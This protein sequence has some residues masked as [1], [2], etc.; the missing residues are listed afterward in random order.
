[1]TIQILKSLLS[2]I[3]LVYL[4]LGALL[5]FFQQHFIYF[6]SSEVVDDSQP[7]IKVS[8]DN[9]I[10]NVWQ[11]NPGNKD[12]AI[13]FCGNAQNA[14]YAIPQF[15]KMITDKTI[16]IVDYRGYGGSSGK[17]GEQA[18]FTDAVNI[19]DYIKSYHENIS[20]IGQSI[21]SGVAVYLASKREV[22]KLILNTPFDSFAAVAKH[23]YPFFPI[24]RLLND[25]F[26]SLS[27][28]ASI[29]AKTLIVIA[30]KD[31]II[32]KDHAYK[33]AAAFKPEQLTIVELPNV[34][35]NT[36]TQHPL[37]ESTI[38]DFLQQPVKADNE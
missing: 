23:H 1:M 31:R 5:Y 2:I 19:Y 10:I 26:D 9:E 12:A 28:V 32:P 8:S 3:V 29:K 20:V 35:H 15:K 7:S 24:G 37:Y 16:Y 11:V 34:G 4:G 36:L 18:L 30:G 21:G 6:P 25:K 22:K 38:S 27:R 13:Y 14:Y 33:L 17:P